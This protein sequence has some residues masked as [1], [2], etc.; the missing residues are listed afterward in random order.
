MSW[1]KFD[2]HFILNNK[3]Q[4][5]VL[6]FDTILEIKV[7]FRN[8]STLNSIYINGLDIII[9]LILGINKMFV[10]LKIFISAITVAVN[11]KHD[12]EAHEQTIRNIR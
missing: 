7:D 1:S 5:I 2:F 6:Y 10:I 9:K 8:L 4:Y 11:A 12:Y 3:D